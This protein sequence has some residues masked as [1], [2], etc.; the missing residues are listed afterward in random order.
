[1]REV[2]LEVAQTYKNKEH[3][4]RG[5]DASKS[6]IVVSSALAHHSNVLKTWIFI[7]VREDREEGTGKQ[8]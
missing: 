6:L 3:S 1:M 2:G 7:I 8:S 4:I 5:F